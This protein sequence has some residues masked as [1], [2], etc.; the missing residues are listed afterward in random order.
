MHRTPDEGV[1]RP[2][3]YLIAAIMAVAVALPLAISSGQMKTG[4]L[5]DECFGDNC[6]S[7]VFASK[8]D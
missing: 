2:I 7:P 8:T 4:G 3:L 5:F 1:R 6:T